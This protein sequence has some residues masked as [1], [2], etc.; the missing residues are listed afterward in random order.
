[1]TLDS[2]IEDRGL[3]SIDLLKIDVQ[4]AEYGVLERAE[5]SFKKGLINL[6]FMEIIIGPTYKNQ[7]DHADYL[8]IL[9]GYGFTLMGFHN[10]TYD[11]SG[12]VIQLDALFKR[13]S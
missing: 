3:D 11:R 6:I 7:K 4:G 1:M 5:K 13:R 8:G 2:F 10:L 12:L 9:D